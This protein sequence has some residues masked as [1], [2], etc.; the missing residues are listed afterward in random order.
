MAHGNGP[1]G[2]SSLVAILGAS[3][4]QSQYIL[5]ALAAVVAAYILLAYVILPA[6][7]THHERQ[8]GLAVR[9][10]VTQTKQ[11]IRWAMNQHLAA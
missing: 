2:L 9:P 11:G 10:M 4:A 5:I 3:V 1:D 8:P 6:A 7:W